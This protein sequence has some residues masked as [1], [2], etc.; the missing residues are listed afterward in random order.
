[1]KQKTFL[2][3]DNVW[4]NTKSIKQALMFLQAPFHPDSLVLVTTRAQRTLELLGIDG[5]AC[6]EMPKL[7]QGD[8]TNLFLHYAANGQQFT[9][10]KDVSFID[11]CVER[12]Y[13]SKGDGGGF[14]YHPLALEALGRQL[15]CLGK[16]PCEWAKILSSVWN[17]NAFSGENQVFDVLRISFDLLR[18][19]EQALLM[20]VGFFLQHLYEDVMFD[21]DPI[22]CSER[23][24]GQYKQDE[25]RMQCLVKSLPLPLKICS[26]ETSFCTS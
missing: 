24:C 14:H 15:G 3:I 6:L 16:N 1:M 8:A 9:S 23:L 12:C 18:P 10:E 22:G 4:D 21:Q 5:G 20:D 17:F 19:I 26:R 13:F 25:Q 2:A 11:M 7:G